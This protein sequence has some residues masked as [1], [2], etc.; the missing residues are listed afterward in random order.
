MDEPFSDL[1]ELLKRTLRAEVVRLQER[2]GITMVHVTHD[3]E[4]AMTMGDKIIV[5]NEGHIA[6][7]GD[8]DTVFNEPN[9]LFVARFI[10]SPQINEFHCDLSVDGDRA[11]LT[12]E[13][14]SISVNGK[15]ASSLSGV[16]SG[17]VAACV[18]PQH[19]FWSD[20]AP[21]EGIAI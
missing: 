10:G 7:H 8:P 14:V 15:T 4:E 19:L 20:T 2:L 18:R 5:M 13:A 1:D 12:S 3:Q 6:Q 17:E 9:S 11:Q 21:E 16:T